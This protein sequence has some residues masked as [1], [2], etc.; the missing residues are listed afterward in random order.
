MNHFPGLASIH[1][2][3]DCCLLSS[4]DYRHEPPALSFLII[5]NGRLLN[6]LSDIL[7]NSLSLES[8]VESLWW[9]FGGKTL[10]WF[11]IFKFLHC[12]LCICWSMF[13]FTSLSE[14]RSSPVTWLTI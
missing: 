4:W 12:D 1:D 5:F 6:I 11:F 13:P 2:F 3:P 8:D 14:Q 7:T 9:D 10:P